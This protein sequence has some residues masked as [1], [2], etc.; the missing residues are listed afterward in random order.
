M[1]AFP[2]RSRFT[3]SRLSRLQSPEA[4]LFL[5]SAIVLFAELVFI[6]WVP[7]NVVYVTFFSNLVLMASFLGIGVG[8]LLGR[9]FEPPRLPFWAPLLVIT[10]LFI[11]AVKID[12]RPVLAGSV[13]AQ[14]AASHVADPNYF[15][16]PIIFVLVAGLMAAL[17][18][19]LGPLLRAMP[20]LRAYAIDIAGSIAG[21]AAFALCSALSLPPPVWFATLGVALAARG[22]LRPSGGGSLLGFASVATVVAATIVLQAV[23]GDIW[24]PYYRI[25]MFFPDNGA[26]FLA[27]NGIP[28]QNFYPLNSPQREAFYDQVYRWFPNRTFARVLVIGAGNGTD[29]DGALARGATSVDAVEIDPRILDLGERLHPDRPYADPRVR[30]I[31]DDGRAVLRRTD[32]TYDLIVLAL[33]DSLTLSSIAA[34]AVLI[35]ARIAGTELRRTSPHFFAL[36]AAFLLLETR[37]LA[38]FSLLF[39]ST[40]TVNALVFAAIL[41]SVLAAIG[42]SARWRI[43]GPIPYV[44]LAASLLANYL[45]PPATLLID[46]PVLRYVLAAT[47]AFLPVFFA[48]LVFTA[49]FRD[50]RTADMAF[51]SNVLGAV[52]GGCLEYAALVIGYQQLLVVIAALYAGAFVLARLRLLGDRDL[53]VAA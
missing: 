4:R 21:I 19:P 23:V 45:V 46:P 27:V 39:G 10:T 44:L 35:A 42:V 7:A 13:L 29:V 38:T 17:A 32:Q 30:E 48:N 5:T 3:I 50:T 47:L 2:I 26:P 36:G 9:R 11:L 22:G 31:V 37:N 18:M 33:T 43:R 49:S 14:L 34:A 41:L 53:A 40:W 12:F 8:I 52:V 1:P 51:A 24:S 28:H 6:R 16:L 25:T 20:P 15:V